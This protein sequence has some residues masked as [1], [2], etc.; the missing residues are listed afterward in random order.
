MEPIPVAVLGYGN[1]ARTFHIPFIESLPDLFRLAVVMQRPR[2]EGSSSPAAQKDLPHV[3]VQPTVEQ[4]L[5][6]LPQGPALVIVTTDNASHFGYAKLALEAGKHVLVEKPV[7]VSEKDI[8]ALD[9]LALAK[10]LVCTVY[11]NRRFDGDFLTLRTL[12]AGSK[13][14]P[15]SIG[16]PTYF[17]SRFDRFRP[18]AKGG[19]RENVDPET[20]GGGMLWDLGAH[21]VD[22]AV[23]LFG[24]PE[25]V[26][27]FVRNQRGQGPLQVDDDWLAILH[28]A[29]PQPLAEDSFAPGVQLGGLRVVLGSTCLSAHVQSEQP[30]FRVEGTLGSYVKLGTDPQEGQLKKGWTPRTHPDAFGAYEDTDPHE[31]RMGRLT[32]TQI[33]EEP[34]TAA[35]PPTLVSSDIPTLPG[36]YILLFSNVAEAISAADAATKRSASPQQIRESINKVLEIRL[37]NVAL[38]TR[39]LCMIRTSS[40][41]GRTLYL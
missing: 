24:A 31:L 32:T 19:W 13:T 38:A 37:E 6:A 18:I 39:V 34:V 7:S 4:A 20:E 41:E 3:S 40:Q 17:E 35:N 33:R 28:Y 36:R 11:Q 10:G 12:L 25:S 30:R 8:R 15:S 26:T 21:L 2:G 29:K 14:R 1:S 22:Q 27:G 9:E 16:M 23:S 5:A